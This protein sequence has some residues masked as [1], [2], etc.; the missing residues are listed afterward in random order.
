MELHSTL[1][2]TSTSSCPRGGEFPNS[3]LEEAEAMGT[4]QQVPVGIHLQQVP[5]H[6]IKHQ[7]PAPHSCQ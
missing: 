5:I 7:P 2:D 1:R 4:D 6:G 3:P